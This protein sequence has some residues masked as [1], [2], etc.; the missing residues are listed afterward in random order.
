LIKYFSFLKI[1]LHQQQKKSSIKS[2]DK[3]LAK[4]L[5]KEENLKCKNL[6]RPS[7]GVSFQ[8]YKK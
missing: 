8:Q 6:T 3:E 1:K 2:S 4:L 7:L 5:Q